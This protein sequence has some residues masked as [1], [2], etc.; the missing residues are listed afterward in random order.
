MLAKNVSVCGFMHS[1]I[2]RFGG[3]VQQLWTGR[4]PLSPTSTRLA[5]P[6]LASLP[7]VARCGCFGF[8]LSNRGYSYAPAPNGLVCV[9]VRVC[10][11]AC[12]LP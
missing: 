8:G 4:P 3:V 12:V 6:S 2:S 11:R 10:V 1:V 9:C 7:V 5:S